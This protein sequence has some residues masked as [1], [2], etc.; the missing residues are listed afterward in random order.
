MKEIMLEYRENVLF[1]YDGEYDGITRGEEEKGNRW[2]MSSWPR[3][4]LNAKKLARVLERTEKC[5]NWED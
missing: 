4:G 3:S 5:A 1:E 2:Q